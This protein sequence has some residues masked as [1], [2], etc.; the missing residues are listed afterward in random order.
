[1]KNENPKMNFVLKLLRLQNCRKLMPAE[2][3]KH[4]T[5]QYTDAMIGNGMDA[6]KAPNFPKMEKKIMKAAEI[7]ITLRLPILV[8]AKSP[9]FSV[10]VVIPETPPSMPLSNTP[11]PSQPVP[12]LITDGGIGVALP[13]LAD[14]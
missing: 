10:D 6:K 11:T 2:H 14:A 1:M 4:K 8:I 5:M 13:Y 3:T 12:R 9:T 7:C